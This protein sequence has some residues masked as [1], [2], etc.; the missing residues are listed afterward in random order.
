MV[1]GHHEGAPRL[2][3]WAFDRIVETPFYVD[4]R[5]SIGGDVSFVTL[6]AR[7]SRSIPDGATGRPI[8]CR[9]AA[10]LPQIEADLAR[11]RYVL[12][13]VRSKKKE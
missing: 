1:R 11:T 7:H 3:F 4:C 2:G 12:D 8:S 9:P 6:S 5:K 10:K 13:R